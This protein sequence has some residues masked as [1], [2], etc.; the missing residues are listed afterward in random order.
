MNYL[1]LCLCLY[2]IIIITFS[3]KF[4]FSFRMCSFDGCDINTNCQNTPWGH[5]CT[6]HNQLMRDYRKAVGNNNSDVNLRG[7][8]AWANAVCRSSR[9]SS[10]RSSSRSPDGK[11]SSGQRRTPSPEPSPEPSQYQRRTNSATYR[12][13]NQ[14]QLV[15]QPTH[16]TVYLTP[17]V[18]QMLVIPNGYLQHGFQF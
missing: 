13:P 3:S 11:H 17:P 18:Y 16:Q 4:C 5:F 8:V 9:R 2:I 6:Y 10:R 14:Q 15:Q 1:I 7:F 12:V